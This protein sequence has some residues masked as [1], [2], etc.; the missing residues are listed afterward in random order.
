MNSINIQPAYINQIITRIKIDIP[1]IILNEKCAVRV[2]CYDSDNNL[3][4]T[5]E[6]ELVKPDY[7]EWLR[8]ID[9]ID[10]VCEKYNFTLIDIEHK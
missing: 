8:D 3:I 7:D 1:L 2:L 5:H 6:F 10:Y 9:L 4:K